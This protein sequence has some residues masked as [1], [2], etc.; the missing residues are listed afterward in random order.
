VKLAADSRR[1][2]ST[3]ARERWKSPSQRD[4][5][6]TSASNA[7]SNGVVA[8]QPR[9]RPLKDQLR[10]AKPQHLLPGVQ[11]IADAVDVERSATELVNRVLGRVADEI[12]GLSLDEFT[13]TGR[14]V[15]K[16]ALAYLRGINPDQS[17]RQQPAIG[18]ARLDRVAIDNAAHGR[19][20]HLL[21]V[22]R[23][24]SNRSQDTSEDNGQR[25]R[26]PTR[27]LSTLTQKAHRRHDWGTQ[28][29][30]RAAGSGIGPYPR[31]PRNSSHMG[32]AYSRSPAAARASRSL[33]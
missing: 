27:H 13:K 3:S 14:R 20:R 7:P 23:N 33:A 19:G 15:G 32:T 29:I 16:A 30:R 9:K 1:S 22:R 12:D 24:R 31:A 28:Y 21:A 10:P 17:N 11:P 25:Q 18:Q 26:A 5:T 6:P 4:H 2:R 8:R